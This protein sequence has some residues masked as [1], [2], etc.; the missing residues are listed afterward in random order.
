LLCGCFVFTRV[1][2]GYVSAVGLLAVIVCLSVCLSQVGVL[3]R[4]L[5]LRSRNQFHTIT[6]GL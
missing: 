5:N 2:L 3:L 4:R 6:H 1:T